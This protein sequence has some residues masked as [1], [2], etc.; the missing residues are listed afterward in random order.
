MIPIPVGPPPAPEYRWVGA[1]AAHRIRS[2]CTATGVVLLVCALT[3]GVATLS[4]WGG[5]PTA[6]HPIH[7]IGMILAV[8]VTVLLLIVGVAALG[9]RG[10]VSPEH[11]DVAGGA[12]LRRLALAMAVFAVVC[13]SLACAVLLLTASAVE[14][15][16]GVQGAGAAVGLFLLLPVSCAVVAL[17]GAILARGAL[18]PPLP[19]APGRVVP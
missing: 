2:R 8:M 9:G 13:A 1:L 10:Y 19:R 6:D 5:L 3:A 14:Q 15:T 16:D 11:V 17:V 4:L 18:R 7:P 12:V